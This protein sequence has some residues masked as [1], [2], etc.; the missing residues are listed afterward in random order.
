LAALLHLGA[1]VQPELIR[2]AMVC[3]GDGFG[4][5]HLVRARFAFS[6]FSAEIGQNAIFI[7][8]ENEMRRMGAE[9]R[10]FS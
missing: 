5:P 9:G 3:G 2:M 8:T 7:N 10:P 4:Y 6:F 1:F